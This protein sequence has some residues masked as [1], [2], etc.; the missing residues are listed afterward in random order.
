MHCPTVAVL[1]CWYWYIW[2]ATDE[3]EASLPLELRGLQMAGDESQ[4]SLDI[5]EDNE[6]GDLVMRV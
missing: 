6:R 3:D 4:K 5:E 1:C 2:A